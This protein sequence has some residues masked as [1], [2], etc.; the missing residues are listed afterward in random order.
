MARTQIDRPFR[1]KCT[2]G[3]DA[4]LL[5]SFTGSER[6]STPYHYVL[7]VLAESADLDIIGL[8]KKPLVVTIVLTDKQERHIHGNIRSMKLLATG[9]DGLAAYQIEMTPWFWFLHLFSDCRIF[10]NK[11]VL[12]IVK[13]VFSD[14][15]FTDYRDDTQGS[16]QPVEY[17]VQYR[18]TDF[19]FVS[20]LL[21]QEGIFYYFE[22]NNEKATMVLADVKEK[23]TECPHQGTVQFMPATGGVL[24]EDTINKLE[25][26]VQVHTGKASLTDYDFEKPASDLSATEESQDAETAGEFYDFP[27]NYTVKGE[28]DRYARVRLEEQEVKLVTIRAEGNCMGLECGYKFKLKDFYR[29]AANIDYVITSLSQSGQNP[30]YRSNADLSAFKYSNH[31]EAIPATVAFRPPRIAKK[32]VIRRCSDGGCGWQ[33]R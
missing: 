20:R 23:F 12:D 30:S 10:Q 27:G 25:Q 15:G 14:R 5:E 29:D 21:E 3:D 7:R 11:S 18:E 22:Q 9:D 19:N 6:I 24:A 16:Y 26:E 2:L 17:C 28:G 32:P 33:V 31:F 8:L 1:L 13:Q 4:L